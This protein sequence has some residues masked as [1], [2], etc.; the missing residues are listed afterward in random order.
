VPAHVVTPS[1]VIL[2]H[3]T[4]EALE[5]W[6]AE[7]HFAAF[8]PNTITDPVQFHADVMGARRLGYWI[9]EQQLEIGLRGMAVALKDRKGNCL[10]AIGTT[11]PIQP[12]SREE[13]VARLLPLLQETAQAL[14]QVV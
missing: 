8:A 2:A 5:R 7:H 11:M 9:T 12:Y 10:G 6:I 14:R 3:Y 13:V 1:L 4:D